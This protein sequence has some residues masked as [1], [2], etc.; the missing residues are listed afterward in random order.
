MPNNIPDTTGAVTA[1]PY[2]VRYI[3]HTGDKK[4]DNFPEFDTANVT[5]ANVQAF[6]VALGAASQASMYEGTIQDVFRTLPDK[7]DATV[8]DRSEVQNVINILAK[9]A[10]GR[11][12]AC[13]VRAPVAG[14]F[15]PN[16]DEI[17][18]AST[19]LAAVFTAFLAM[20]PAGFQIIS[21]RYTG[22]KQFNKATP[23]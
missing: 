8:G 3:D 14:C 23:I 13:L 22:R 10:D 11:T 19:E 18:P 12:S 2:S 7:N 6:N 4:G 16:S 21:A 5:P 9:H 17:D 20:L 1:I 15:I